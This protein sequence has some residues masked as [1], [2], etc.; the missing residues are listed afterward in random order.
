M[1]SRCYHIVSVPKRLIER[2]Y[3]SWLCLVCLCEQSICI[4]S[5]ADVDF[6]FGDHE[7]RMS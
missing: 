5:Y 4:V 6:S 7:W 2:I 1:Y 3:F